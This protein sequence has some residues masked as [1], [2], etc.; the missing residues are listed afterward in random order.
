[1]KESKYFL[2]VFLGT[3]GLFAVTVLLLFIFFNRNNSS[4]VGSKEILI[5]V[6]IP[7]EETEEFKLS[8]DAYTLREAL[9]E[10]KLIKGQ[11]SAYGFY[12]VEV[13]GRLADDSKSE[14]WSITKGGEYIEYGV[15]MINIQDK[16]QY[17]LTLMEGY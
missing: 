17:E 10:E 14:W 7:G 9:D 6:I 3:L 11:E 2:K 13:N 8:T 15:D 4:S 12:I 16:D 5:Q 1:M